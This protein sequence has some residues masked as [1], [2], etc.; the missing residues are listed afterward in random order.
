MRHR[1]SLQ[2]VGDG[3]CLR[4]VGLQ[5]FE[6]RRRGG[7]EIAHFDPRPKRLRAGADRALAAGIDAEREPMPRRRRSRRDGE[8]PH[9][10]DGRQRLAAKTQSV[11]CS[12]IAGRQLGSG[13]P[14]DREVEVGRNHAAAV[15]DDPDKLAAS[16]FDGD[17]DSGRAGIKRVLDNLFDGRG[18][19]FDNLAGS[20]AVD[21]HAVETLDGHG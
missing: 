15:V 17:L 18:W 3:A 8:Q 21:Q 13:M 5:E 20:D 1:E 11:D 10:S 19:A 9:G 6:A 2:H 7:E 12:K 16:G 4:S 14:L